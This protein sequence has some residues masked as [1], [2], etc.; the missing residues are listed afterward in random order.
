MIVIQ[1]DFNHVDPRGRLRLS[2]LAMHRETPFAEI[3][4]RREP[5]LFVDG[6]DIVEGLLS[7]D[8]AGDWV[9]AADWSTQRRIEAWPRATVLTR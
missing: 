2:D 7:E 4:A 6:D 8:P 9:G 1:A 3:G 5:I